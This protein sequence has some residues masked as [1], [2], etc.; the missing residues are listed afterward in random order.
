MRLLAGLPASLTQFGQVAVLA[1][2]TPANQVS[3][4]IAPPGTLGIGNPNIQQNRG[5]YGGRR[6]EGLSVAD[7]SLISSPSRCLLPPNPLSVPLAPRISLTPLPSLLFAAQSVVLQLSSTALAS[8]IAPPS[9]AVPGG[10]TS[11]RGARSHP[12][13][14]RLHHRIR[15]TDH[16]SVVDKESHFLHTRAPPAKKIFPISCRHFPSRR[17]PLVI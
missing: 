10:E 4:L 2:R 8:L 9:P 11:R 6:E 16:A 3:I 1:K 12:C 17:G 7:L 14:R 15:Y 13:N 5:T